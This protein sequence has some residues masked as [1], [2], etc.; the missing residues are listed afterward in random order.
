MCAKFIEYDPLLTL[1]MLNDP[2]DDVVAV[3]VTGSVDTDVFATPRI[4]AME[5]V[6]PEMLI[7]PD[8]PDEIEI[9]PS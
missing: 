5:T 6:L 4:E 3:E 9:S 2:S 1:L 8:P 7:I